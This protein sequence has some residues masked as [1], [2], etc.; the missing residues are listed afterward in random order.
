MAFLQQLLGMGRSRRMGSWG[1]RGRQAGAL[2]NPLAR[3]L[4]GGLATYGARRYMGRRRSSAAN[5]GGSDRIT[6]Y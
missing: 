3:V 5:I 4:L 1:G 6:T 2:S